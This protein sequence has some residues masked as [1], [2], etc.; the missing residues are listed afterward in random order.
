[1]GEPGYTTGNLR[2]QVSGLGSSKR[3]RAETCDTSSVIQMPPNLQEE[4]ALRAIG[5]THIAGI[6]EAGR[7]AWAGPVCAAA[8]VLP[9]ERPDLAELL[10]GVCD[11][12]QLSPARREALLPVIQDVA[13]SVGVG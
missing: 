1:M 7:G 3:G 8:V 2:F 10:N 9:L 11:S 5:Y 4:L 13:E 6:D 12:K